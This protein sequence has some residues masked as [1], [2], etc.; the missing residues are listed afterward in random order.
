M[1]DSILA[2]LKSGKRNHIDTVFPGTD[3]SLRIQI[4]S[5]QEI[6]DSS[7]AADRVFKLADIQITFQNS[8]EYQNEKNTQQLFRACV[9]PETE[10]PF[11]ADILEFRKLTTSEERDC[12]IDEYNKLSQD[13][14]PSPENMAHDEFDAIVEAVKK[15][16]K[17][18]IGNISSTRLLKKLLHSM[19]SQPQ[20]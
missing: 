7:I 2:K 20:N 12:L 9:D 3:A 4:L 19:A 16:P 13:T 18:T 15:N 5:N 14:N 8:N 11:A 1:S 6:L 17:E 10:K